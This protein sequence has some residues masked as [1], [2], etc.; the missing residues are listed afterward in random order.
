MTKDEWYDNLEIK[1]QLTIDNTALV[2]VQSP[3]GS[4]LDISALD[5]MTPQD[6]PL[7]HLF[8]SLYT[9][10]DIYING[11]ITSTTDFEHGKQSGGGALLI[12]HGWVGS[13]LQTNPIAVSPPL[14]KLTTSGTQIKSGASL[15]NPNDMSDEPGQIFNNTS[16]GKLYI[17]TGSSWQVSETYFSGY[18]DTLFLVKNDGYNPANLDLGNLT[19]HGNIT[20]N[21]PNANVT[22]YD[23][24][25][26]RQTSPSVVLELSSSMII[27][28][29]LQVGA[30]LSV[31]G[32]IGA[33]GNVT[34]NKATP[35][36]QLKATSG[37]PIIEFYDTSTLKMNLAY[38]AV[39]DYLY[40]RDIVGSKDVFQATHAGQLALPVNGSTGGLRIGDDAYLYRGSTNT[41][42]VYRNIEPGAGTETG[43][44]GEGDRYWYGLVAKYV[45]CQNLGF[46]DSYDDLSIAKL[47]GEKN[48][49]LPE[50]Y[51]KTKLK[52]PTDDPFKIIKGSKDE[53]NTE[54]FFDVGKVNSFLMGCVKALAKKQDEHDA[55]LLKMLN[56]V[57]S[58]RA[59]IAS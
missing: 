29:S 58:L 35:I 49:T 34:I 32:V 36:L 11:S 22:F 7:L 57:E 40:L 33:T 46:F 10:N 8:G 51:D 16:D 18:Y 47:W 26:Y 2:K 50:D 19:A 48:P 13:G 12:S 38:S 25:L 15:P 42:Y 41:L 14:I 56:E 24:N 23:I 5:G 44:L 54:E 9:D 31:T 45:Y 1:N 59:Q 43:Y 28:Q 55:L 4:Y 6:T 52:P 17:W 53:A 37:D 30:G 20:I 39:G 3:N 21:Q 27:D